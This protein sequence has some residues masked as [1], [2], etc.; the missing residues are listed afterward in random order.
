MQ[1]NRDH[2]ALI[3]VW[4]AV[5]DV[6]AYII[7]LISVP[8]FQFTF[9]TWRLIMAHVISDE[10]IACGTCAGACPA[11]AIAEGD[12]KLVIDPETCVDCGTCVDECPM[13]AISAS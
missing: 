4:L 13:N 5:A 1:K 11:E 7:T 2:H 9:F 10:C 12:G 6:L 3:K 8:L